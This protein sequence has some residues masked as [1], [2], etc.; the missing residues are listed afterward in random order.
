MTDLNHSELPKVLLV[1][2]EQEILVALEDLLEDRYQL[3]SAT[4]PVE[5][6]DIVKANPDLAVIVSDQ[7][8]PEMPGNLFLAR[9]RPYSD[10]DTILLTGYADLSAVISAINEGA[11]SGYAAKPW[12]PE[13]LRAMVAA[14]AERH[15]LRAALRFEQSAFVGL[16]EASADQISVLDRH[17]RLIRGNHDR[18]DN[19]T[20]GEARAKDEAALASGSYSEEDLQSGGEE[21]DERWTRVRRIPFGADG[22]ERHLL[23]IESDETD[24]RRAARRLHQAEKLQALGTLAGG[25]AHDFNNLLAAILGN[26]ELAERALDKPDRLARFLSNARSAAGRGS[27]ITRR[28]LSFSRQRDLAA[29]TF[30]PDTAI[31]DLEELVA[32]TMAG[33]VTLSLDLDAD[34]AIHADPGQFELALVNLCINAR[35]AMANGGEI[36]LSSARVPAPPEMRHT[37]DCIRIAVRDSGA[38][39]PEHLR[40]RV[41][42]PFFTTKAQGEGT[43]LG[44]PMVRAMVEA[45]GGLVTIDSSVGEGTTVALWFPRL[46][47]VEAGAEGVASETETRSLRVLAVEDDAEVRAVLVA[48]LTAAGHEVL[49]ADGPH[50]A[51]QRLQS[52]AGI[53]LLVTDYAMPEI[54]GLDLFRLASERRPGL[55]AILVTGFADVEDGS[56][57]LPVL[58]KPF[59]GDQLKAAI[60]RVLAP[61]G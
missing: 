8:M 35:D 26:L 53:D 45:A 15:Q 40:D 23:K 27:A 55:P 22:N 2:D 52:D 48:H 20:E 54:S 58:T 36:V 51:L 50:A 13:A 49:E 59:T 18:I 31:R 38:G 47:P 17:H 43:G 6:L 60:A 57:P 41:F 19:V 4:S 33:R 21:H 34:G 37:G 39:I 30:L 9:A 1:D 32:R 11:I 16:M 42:E 29:E 61:T 12:E 44:L 10:A 3:L 24:R 14:A 25:I 5:A 7:R 46:D 56:V 28:L